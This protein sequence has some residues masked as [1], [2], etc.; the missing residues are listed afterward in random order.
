MN[1][2]NIFVRTA[3]IMIAVL[4]TLPL[5]AA[6]EQDDK[7]FYFLG[8]ALSRNL[9]ALNLSDSELEELI[10]GLRAGV[11][12][13]AEQLD[14]AVYGEKLN[15][16]AQSRMAAASA[17][18][19]SASKAYLDKMAAEKGAVTTASGL[20]YLEQKA[21]AGEQPTATSTVVAHYQ[22]TLRDGTVFDSSVERGQPLTIP[23][24]RVIPC[25][26]E[27]IAMMKPGG[28]SKITCPSA[29][30]YGDKG[31]PPTIPPGAALTFEVELISIQE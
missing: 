23:L 21:G 15:A 28:K 5:Q 25:W 30:A 27:A 24:N 11:A 2:Q 31:S 4:I 13:D 8:T 1:L 14:E 22:G 16:L 9:V 18:E 29:I 12:G 26:T 6:E 19:V 7:V 20:V 10:K 3:S 17:I